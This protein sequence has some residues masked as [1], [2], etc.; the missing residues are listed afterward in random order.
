MPWALPQFP[1]RSTKYNLEY[2]IALGQFSRYDID[3]IV[4]SIDGNLTAKIFPLQITLALASH[5]DSHGIFM[6]K[7]HRWI[8]DLNEFNVML[9]FVWITLDTRRRKASRNS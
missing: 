9:E 1:N 5:S 4:V 8:R 7:Y 6:K 3:G 2:F